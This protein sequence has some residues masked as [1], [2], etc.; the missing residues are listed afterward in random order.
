MDMTPWRAKAPFIYEFIYRRVPEVAAADSECCLS[1]AW[2]GGQQSG[3]LSCYL[4]QGNAPAA[5]TVRDWMDAGVTSEDASSA[6]TMTAFD[7]PARGQATNIMSLLSAFNSSEVSVLHKNQKMDV[8]S[9]VITSLKLHD[10][11]RILFGCTMQSVFVWGADALRQR[12]M[13]LLM[14]DIDGVYDVGRAHVV[15]NS[16]RGDVGVWKAGS[17]SHMWRYNDTRRFRARASLLDS[18]P[19]ITALQIASS[20]DGVYVGDSLGRLSHCDFR[21][22]HIEHLTSDHRGIL[23]CLELA[24][25]TGILAGTYTGQLSL[26]DTRFMRAGGQAGS[27]GCV[28][29]QYHAPAGASAATINSVRVC[30]HDSDILACAIGAGVYIHAKEPEQAQS[31]LFSHEAHQTQV[32]DFCWHPDRDYMYTIG[33]AESGVGRG[34]GEI[35]IWRPSDSVL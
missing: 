3:T 22:P 2:C 32:T 16:S 30:P 14:D 29:R 21:A 27:Q 23:K 20:D 13:L 35:Q 10:S 8:N 18:P 24:G 5:A 1:M 31:L 34:S 6:I 26:L 33:S 28:V 17:Q 12:A 25:D 15:A 19:R 4:S 9:T 7:L 11:G